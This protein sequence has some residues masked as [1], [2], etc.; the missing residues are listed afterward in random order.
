MQQA[1]LGMN[2]QINLRDVTGDDRT[3]TESEPRQNIFICSGVVFWPHP[4]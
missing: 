3:R 1:G 4:E 2:R